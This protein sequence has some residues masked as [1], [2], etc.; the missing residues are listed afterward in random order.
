MHTHALEGLPEDLSMVSMENARAAFRR[1][2]ETSPWDVDVHTALGVIAHLAGDYA[3]ATTAFEEALR[4]RPEDYSLWNKLGATLANSGHSEAAKGAYTHALRHKPNYM[5]AWANMG[6]S[7][8]NLGQYGAAAQ[9]FL[10]A[11]T[12]NS[13]AESVWGYLQTAAVMLGNEEALQMV[14]ARDVDGLTR[15]LGVASGNPAELEPGMGTAALRP[16]DMGKPNIS[17]SDWGPNDLDRGFGV[18]G[19][20]KGVLGGLDDGFVEKLSEAFAE[21]STPE[22]PPFQGE[23]GPGGFDPDAEVQVY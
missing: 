9:H 21:G 7:F 10:K 23:R 15:L 20:G 2:V 3:Q 6:I 4:M 14:H 1:A 22:I 18:M 13:N 5:R 17:T 19:D 16:R 11:L 8:S 12:L